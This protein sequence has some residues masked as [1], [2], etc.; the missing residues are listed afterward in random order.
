[1]PSIALRTP[2]GLVAAELAVAQI[3][4]VDD[5]ADGG[6]RRVVESHPLDEHLERAAV[7]DVRELGLEH[8]EPQLAGL[9]T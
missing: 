3:E 2:G 9:G 7:A 6:E 4:V 1:M 8:V 5:L